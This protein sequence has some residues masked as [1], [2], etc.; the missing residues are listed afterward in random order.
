MSDHTVEPRQQHRSKQT[1]T[2]ESIL[3]DNGLGKWHAIL[4]AEDV[5]LLNAHKI[6]SDDLK[7]MGLTAG[8]RR[9]VIELF[10]KNANPQRPDGSEPSQHSPLRVRLTNEGT[11]VEWSKRD[12][13]K[14]FACFL[15][16]HKGS[17]AMEARFLYEKLQDTIKK[18]CFLDSDD[19]RVMTQACRDCFATAL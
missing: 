19:L 6:T 16:H 4:E 14:K 12:S 3:D 10:C 13:G 1:A 2:L 11:L 5:T 17:C 15:S 9:D 7:E 8:A 18:E